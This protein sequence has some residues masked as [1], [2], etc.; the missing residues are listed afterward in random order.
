[1]KRLNLNETW[2][3][4]LKMWK[5][6]AMKVRVAIKAGKEWDVVILKREWL[7]SHGFENIRIYHNCFFC[8]YAH[9]HNPHKDIRGEGCSL[10]LARKIDKEFD[11]QDTDYEYDQK[12]I[13]FYKKLVELNKI[14]LKKRKAVEK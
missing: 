10:C 12:P 7:S 3:L 4:C 11:C 9:Q 5:W 2:V 13:A 14:R 1:M 6:I 8:E